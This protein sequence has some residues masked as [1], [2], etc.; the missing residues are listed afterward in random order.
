MGGITHDGDRTGKDTSGKLGGNKEYGYN[1][2][3][4]ELFHAFFIF[5]GLSIFDGFITVSIASY[6]VLI[7]MIV[8]TKVLDV[9]L[10]VL[11]H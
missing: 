4:G 5:L 1:R 10:K 3:A 6:F 11:T 8:T 9:S 2:N 7:T